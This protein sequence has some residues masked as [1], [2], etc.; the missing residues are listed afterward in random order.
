MK[1][2]QTYESWKN[3]PPQTYTARNDKGSSSR[4]GKMI[5]DRNL[6]LHKVIKSTEN[7]N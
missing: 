2:L 5:P 1:T 6:A 7:S 3:S 4:Q